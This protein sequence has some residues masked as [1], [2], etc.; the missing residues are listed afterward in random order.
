MENNAPKLTK[1][2]FFRMPAVVIPNFRTALAVQ[3]GVEKNILLK[4]WGGLGD[5]IC[6]EPTLRYALKAFKD[7]KV[8]LASPI[9]ELF[10]HLEFHEV[11]DTKKVLP[12]EDNY[13]VFNT[14]TPPDDSNL[15]WQFFSHCLV[16]CVDFASMC[17][18]RL[19]LPVKDRE[20]FLTGTPP[21]N[22]TIAGGIPRHF[23][24]VHAGRHWSSKTF[25][26][27]WWNQVLCR[28]V[29]KNLIPVLI[30]ADTDDNRG[31]VDVDANDCI[32]LRNK[33]SAAETIYLLQRANIL[34]TN[35]SS[36]LHMAA[37]TDPDFR[38]N[39][40]FCHIGYVAT[41]K[42]PDYITHWRKGEWQFRE[43]N[44]GLGGIWDV[45]S[46]TPNQDQEITVEHVDE[47]LLR[48]WLPSPE[49]LAAWANSRADF[50]F[51]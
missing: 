47:P 5:Q 30:G 51:P 14:I 35:D 7:Y 16:N 27:D 18:L 28:L 34:I 12:V 39:T 42:H 10:E 20:I 26:A 50:L 44:F 4:T 29:R 33:L 24:F 40:G 49:S 6:A 45:I 3:N 31:T 11:I 32:D 9:P 36:P 19:Q 48:S 1:H 15:V 8:T 23:V 46:N 25:P 17:A 43:T 41:C 21:K 38:A 13:L 37:S 22:P 2:D